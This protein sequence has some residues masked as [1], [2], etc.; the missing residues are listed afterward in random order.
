[1]V[2]V[3][4]GAVVGVVVLISRIG[5]G[6]GI[7]GVGNTSAI[8]EVVVVPR[9]RRLTVESRWPQ[10]NLVLVKH[11]VGVVVEVDVVPQAVVVVVPGGDPRRGRG[12][13][14]DIDQS[15]AVPVVVGPIE[16]PVIVVVPR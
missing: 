1:M 10:H 3:Q 13:L 11:A 14:E 9:V 15:I 2:P 7:R 5:P 8:T 12:L 4:I 6:I 16:N